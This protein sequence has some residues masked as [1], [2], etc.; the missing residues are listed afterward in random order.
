M[1]PGIGPAA[2]GQQGLLTEYHGEGFFQDLLHRPGIRL[3]LPAVVAGAIKGEF[4]EI[5][6]AQGIYD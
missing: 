4:Y 1:N 6:I 3:D 2:S 5:P